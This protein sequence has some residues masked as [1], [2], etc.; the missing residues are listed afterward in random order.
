VKRWIEFINLYQKYYSNTLILAG[1]KA[2]AEMAKTIQEA[3]GAGSIVGNASLHEMI[4]WVSG[5]Q[6]V[7]TNNTMAAHLSA[8]C[9]RPAVIIANGDNYIRFT[10]YGSAGIDNIATV[11][12]EV[13]QQRRRRVGDYS[14]HYTAVSAD[15]ASIT[16]GTVLNELEEILELNEMIESSSPVQESQDQTGIGVFKVPVSAQ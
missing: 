6:A 15:I 13:F 8:A 2:E 11:Y 9:N 14:L 3:T 10:E 7:L 12:P 1:G 5:A 16:A 4:D